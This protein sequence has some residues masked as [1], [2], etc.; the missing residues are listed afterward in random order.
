MRY[1]FKIAVFCLCLLLL[2]GCMGVRVRKGDTLY[3]ISK[4]NDVPMRAIIERN[5]LKPPYTLFVGQY[6]YLPKSDT[7]RVRR[8]DTLYSIATKHHMSVSSLAKINGIKEPYTIKSGQMLKVS[9]WVDEKPIFTE[10][11]K[12]QTNVVSPKTDRQEEKKRQAAVKNPSAFKGKANVPKSQAKKKFAWPVKGKITSDFGNGNDG[13]NIAGKSGDPI[14]AA[15][16]GTIAYAGNEL[17]GYGNLVLIRH[18]D[19]WIT[20]YAH[21]RKLLV[22][23]GDVVSKGQKI[24]EMGNTGS[25]KAP[26]LHFE[27]RYKAK[28]V[29]PN[30]Y[31]SK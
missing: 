19:G 1:F 9:S 6:L 26:Q 27:V 30:Q 23:K 7:Y 11:D 8:G 28:V 12:I 31:L 3:S 21:N 20:A 13:I 24:A 2:S 4:K 25:V 14:N 17:K 10:K 22:K 5:D 16:S 18:K 15:D 29:N